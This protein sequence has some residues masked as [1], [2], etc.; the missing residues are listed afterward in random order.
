MGLIGQ[1][2]QDSNI[3]LRWRGT[4]CSK[5]FHL[6]IGRQ[7]GFKDLS[8][9]RWYEPTLHNTLGTKNIAKFLE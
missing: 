5:Q 1:K 2:V 9:E 4:F 6:E 3:D 7:V 8:T